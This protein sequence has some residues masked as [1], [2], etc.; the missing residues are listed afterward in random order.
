MEKLVADIKTYQLPSWTKQTKLEKKDKYN[1]TFPCPLSLSV[2]ANSLFWQGLSM[3]CSF[4]QGTSTHSSVALHVLWGLPASLWCFPWFAVNFYFNIVFW[5]SC[6]GVSAPA[7]EHLSF[8][9][10]C[11]CFGIFFP[12][13][14]CLIINVPWF[15][16]SFLN[17]SKNAPNLLD[18]LSCVLQWIWSWPW[19]LL[20]PLA[21]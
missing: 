11:P 4:L 9:L 12:S 7:L 17:K 1:T 8:L 18:L 6:W 13:L 15:F 2:P 16:Y 3:G 5:G 19:F 10:H 20:T 14:L 21:M